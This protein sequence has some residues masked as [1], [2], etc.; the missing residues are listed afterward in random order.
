MEQ[1]TKEEIICELM[2]NYL[3]E[4][5]T[6]EDYKQMSED[7]LLNFIDESTAEA[8]ENWTASDVLDAVT[9]AAD[10]MEIF[11]SSKNLIKEA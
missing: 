8:Y 11:L 2:G 1:V 7:E 3:C 4:W 5:I 10:S 9:M 6:P